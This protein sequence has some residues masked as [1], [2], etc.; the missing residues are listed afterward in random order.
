M[1]SKTLLTLLILLTPSAIV[2]QEPQIVSGLPIVNLNRQVSPEIKTSLLDCAWEI[3]PDVMYD[4]NGVTRS[5]PIRR[6]STQS[7]PVKIDRKMRIFNANDYWFEV[8]GEL[9]LALIFHLEEQFLPKAHLDVLAI[10]RFKPTFELIDAIDARFDDWPQD[11]AQLV[12]GFTEL[13]VPSGGAIALI[14][15][16]EFPNKSN[17][18]HRFLALDG[19]KLRVVY[20][21]PVLTNQR[22]CLVGWVSHHITFNRV[23]TLE[24][25]GS[26]HEITVERNFKQLSAC[27]VSIDPSVKEYETYRLTWDSVRRVYVGTLVERTDG[28]QRQRVSAI[29]AMLFYENTGTFSEDILTEKGFDLWN[30]PFDSAYATF[31]IVEVEGV[32]PN[33]S[34]PPLRIELVAR[35]RPVDGVRREITVRQMDKVRNGS[36]NGK[37]YAG[38]WI[39]NTGCDPVY[40]NARIIGRKSRFRRTIDFGCGE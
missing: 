35:Y 7:K 18:K 36:A 26:S 21:L 25:D 16:R 13:D 19:E 23:P 20:D 28:R 11:E 14:N 12:G 10:Y 2:A 22:N 32:P 40:L 39:K 30:A 5:I 27:H 8:N 1:L 34:A 29:K 37:G 24:S 9:R 33:A 4:D 38:F 6:L 15:R 31:V 3:F 17:E